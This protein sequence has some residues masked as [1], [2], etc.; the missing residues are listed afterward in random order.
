MRKI[1]NI[2]KTL[3]ILVLIIVNCKVVVHATGAQ[4]SNPNLDNSTNSNPYAA[5][6]QNKNNQATNNKNNQTNS[7]TPWEDFKK[8]LQPIISNP[9]IDDN[10]KKAMQPYLIGSGSIESQKEIMKI[11]IGAPVTDEETRK[12][13][14]AIAKGTANSLISAPGAAIV[15]GDWENLILGPVIT[16]TKEEVKE[17]KK[18][19]EE[20]TNGNTNVPS[21][22]TTS[23]TTPKRT[24]VATHTTGEV[25]EEADNFI[26]NGEKEANDVISKQ[27]M[28]KLSDTIYNILLVV[29]MVIAVLL[30][31]ILGIKFI[32]EGVEGKAN[33]KSALLPYILGCV[34]VFG[35]FTIWKIVV[36]VLQGIQ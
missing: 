19:D 34:V 15:E 23:I 21:Q 35:S 20:K 29:A 27:E 24:S 6:Q 30:G 31:A 1:N 4:A 13:I 25:I 5:G 32:T 10:T 2:V 8:S 3:I 28:Q 11:L 17:Q 16:N 33:V 7:S 22:G 36:T 26:R 14:S 18:K 12:T 9:L